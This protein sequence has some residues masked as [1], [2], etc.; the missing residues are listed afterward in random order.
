MGPL[1][2]II[3]G[4]LEGLTEFLPVSSTGHLILASHLLRIPE[5]EALKSFE[6]SIQ[7]GAICAVLALYGK[8]FFDLEILKRLLVAFLPTAAVGFALYPFIKGFLLGSEAVVVIALGV[9][10]IALIL[11]DTFHKE[12]ESAVDELRKMSYRQAFGIGFFQSIAVV[13]GVSRS[14]ASIVGGLLLGLRR[15]AIVQ[16]SFLLAVPTMAA[17]TGLDLIRSYGSFSRAEVG[18]IGIGFL[19]AFLTALP[20]MRFFLMFVRTGTF[21]PFGVYRVILAAAFALYWFL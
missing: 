12:G 17:A 2:A 19:A 9:G 8:R 7:L 16:F 18:V 3:L 13:P 14:A 11:F 1:E 21:L 20:V 10:G 4:V 5:T 6:I 15:T